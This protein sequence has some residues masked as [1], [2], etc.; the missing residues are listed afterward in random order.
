MTSRQFSSRLGGGLLGLP[1]ALFLAAFFAFPL[2]LA[3]SLA[4][5]TVNSQTLA[6]EGFTLTNFGRF[7]LDPFYLSAFAR[8]AGISIAATLVSILLSY[9]LAWHLHSLRSET[10]RSWLTLIVLLPLMLSLVISAFAWQILLGP[11]GAVSSALKAGGL[12]SSGLRLLGT[13]VGVTIV[14]VY[15]F[16]PY[17]V[18][19]IYAAL[20]NID[21][22]LTR[23]ARIHGA[24]KRR[25]FVAVTLPLS[26]PGIISGGLIV[27]SLSMAAFVVPYLV[28]GGRVKVVPLLI[29]N[30]AVQLLDWPGA[31]ALGV[32]LLLVTLACSWAI[33]SLG[34]RLM[35]W[36]RG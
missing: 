6:G 23:A 26:M 30:F 3:G 19:S 34:Q 28:G 12:M 21:P 35:P 33:A 10:M 2:V 5:Q 20:A 17:T 31:A 4:F 16:M 36:E 24:S 13:D 25:A 27:F 29:Y 9:P 32:L 14:T 1:M 7:L 15:S 18:L 11:N 8:T 22:G